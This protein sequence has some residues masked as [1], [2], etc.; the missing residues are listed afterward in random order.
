[1]QRQHPYSR[2]HLNE[3]VSRIEDALRSGDRALQSRLV[4]QSAELLVKRW[5]RLS[6]ADKPAFDALLLRLCGQIDTAAREAFAERLADLRLGPPRTSQALARDP[7]P[8]VAAPLLTR[9]ASLTP[10]FLGTVAQE[11]GEGHRLAIALRSELPP[12]VTD[13]LARHGGERVAVRLLDNPGA[14]FC[15]AGF[16][17][18]LVHSAQSESVTLRLALRPDLPPVHRP[19]LVDLTRSRACAE[20]RFDLDGDRAF[21]DG[22]M[23]EVAGILERDVPEPRL[24]RF[25]S[26]A[27][28]VRQRFATVPPSATHLESWTTLRRTEDVLA[29]L[30][31]AAELPLS[32]TVAAFDAPGP[33][34]LATILRGL[35]FP[36][37]VLKAM[38]TLRHGSE[39]AA[40]TVEA[41]YGLHRRLG[42]LAAR[43]L[44]RF[45][46]LRQ[47]S[48]AFPHESGAEARA[49]SVR[50]GAH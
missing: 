8:R 49:G 46:A 3:L 38:L 48:L 5:S 29:G 11:G 37:T 18:L 45:A 31:R 7:A 22:L 9:C 2:A 17:R 28:F 21:E 1:M 39:C 33:I 20:L 32:M 44:I 30:S 12:D 16:A 50:A 40:A 41:A 25:A 24:A 14:Q 15:E 42:P 43:R 34:C 19:G 23:A 47:G 6:Q 4:L 36:W 27:A 10:D 26:S 35:D 13:R